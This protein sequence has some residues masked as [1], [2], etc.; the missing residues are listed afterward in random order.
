MRVVLQGVVEGEVLFPLLARQGKLAQAEQSAPQGE[1]GP[2]KRHRVL[3]VLGQGEEFLPQ[4]PR[5][6]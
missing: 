4:L 1:V 5:R 3:E 2:Q 6:L